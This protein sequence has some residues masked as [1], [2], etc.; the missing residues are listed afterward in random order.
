MVGSRPLRPLSI[1]LLSLALHK[2]GE[3]SDSALKVLVDLVHDLV[4]ILSSDKAR[5]LLTRIRGWLIDFMILVIRV[6]L[7]LLRGLV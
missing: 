1:L 6:V 2:G 5:V 7:L 3:G 4:K